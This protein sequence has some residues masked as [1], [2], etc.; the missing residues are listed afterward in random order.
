MLHH[1]IAIGHGK[2]TTKHSL[3]RGPPLSCKDSRSEVYKTLHSAVCSLLAARQLGLLVWLTVLFVLCFWLW[4]T[5]FR[6]TTI[7]LLRY[8][9]TT[10]A[11]C[12]SLCQA[13]IFCDAPT[14][15]ESAVRRAAYSQRI[16]GCVPGVR[17]CYVLCTC[18]TSTVAELAQLQPFWCITKKNLVRIIIYKVETSLTM[19]RVGKTKY[20]ATCLTVVPSSFYNIEHTTC[21]VDT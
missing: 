17:L 14:A 16:Y 12:T 18:C 7:I 3:Q 6:I 5:F 15:T 11:G 10:A 19:F 20:T 4:V 8:A 21:G 9:P 1:D 13:A 2:S